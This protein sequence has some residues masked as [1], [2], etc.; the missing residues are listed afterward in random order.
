M[1][2]W[3]PCREGGLNRDVLHLNISEEYR[4]E[5]SLSARR[6]LMKDRADENNPAIRVA[7]RIRS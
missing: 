5:N 4:E 3:V 2:R 1:R 7:I 6:I